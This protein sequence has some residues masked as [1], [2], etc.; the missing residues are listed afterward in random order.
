MTFWKNSVWKVPN[1]KDW[2][3]FHEDYSQDDLY[4]FEDNLDVTVTVHKRKYAQLGVDQIECRGQ[5][6]DC[7]SCNGGC[8]NSADPCCIKCACMG[9]GRNPCNP[10]TVPTCF[11]AEGFQNLCESK[12]NNHPTDSKVLLDS[13][14]TIKMKCSEALKE[15]KD[16]EIK[17]YTINGHP[18]AVQRPQLITNKDAILTMC[19]SVGRRNCCLKLPGSDPSLC[20]EYYSDNN[21]EGVCD[22]AVQ[23]WCEHNQSASVC[24]CLKSPIPRPQCHDARCTNSVAFQTKA[25]RDSECAAME[26]NQYVILDQESKNNVVNP[27]QYQSCTESRQNGTDP[28]RQVDANG[29]PVDGSSTLYYAMMIIGALIVVVLIAIAIKFFTKGVSPRKNPPLSNNQKRNENN[30]YVYKEPSTQPSSQTPSQNVNSSNP[31]QYTGQ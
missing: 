30:P 1:I 7:N 21:S 3:A 26:C 10:G 23:T 4:G 15:L 20:Q 27:N 25:M 31:Y 5:V 29:N 14:E 11:L 2:K 24:A 16:Q 19:S 9:K 13:T 18:I 22:T 8:C 28:N 17:E 6:F 12:Y